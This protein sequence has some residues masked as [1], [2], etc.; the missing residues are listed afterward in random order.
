MCNFS[1]RTPLP[2]ELL[3][4]TFPFLHPR[5]VTHDPR[6]AAVVLLAGKV[7]TAEVSAEILGSFE[8]CTNCE[9]PETAKPQN[10]GYGEGQKSTYRLPRSLR[11]RQ[12][13]AGKGSREICADTQGQN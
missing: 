7:T 13:T 12:P 9:H 11:E 10:H 8:K 5:L 1:R 4:M 6:V 2:R 3:G